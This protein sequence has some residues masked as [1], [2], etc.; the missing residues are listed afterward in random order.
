MLKLFLLIKQRQEEANAIT[1]KKEKELEESN[2]YV[3][4]QKKLELKFARAMEKLS[5]PRVAEE[6]EQRYNIVHEEDHSA[7]N[8]YEGSR[9]IELVKFLIKIQTKVQSR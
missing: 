4:E 3:T 8:Y 5:R 6:C 9:R 1:Q 7:E 2:D